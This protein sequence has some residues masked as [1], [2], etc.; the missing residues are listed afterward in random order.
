MPNKLDYTKNANE[1]PPDFPQSAQAPVCSACLRVL[2]VEDAPE[3]QALIRHTLDGQDFQVDFA[4]DGQQAL[5]RF[6]QSPP[7]LILLDINLP[8][9]ICGLELCATFRAA[10]ASPFP[11]IVM[12]TADDAIETIA[13]ARFAGADGYLVKPVSP[14]QL[15]GLLDTFDAWRLD[16]R[17]PVPR[18]W[19]SWLVS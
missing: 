5:A 16:V 12:L 13:R 8:G 4:G 15:L 6:S 3:L 2:V 9:S 10:N 14:M 17:R 11:V 1:S 7:Q 18:F 19:P